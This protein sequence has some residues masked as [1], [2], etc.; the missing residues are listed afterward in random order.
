MKEVW[1]QWLK[2]VQS[3]ISFPRFLSR[4]AFGIENSTLFFDILFGITENDTKEALAKREKEI[5]KKSQ[6]QYNCKAPEFENEWINKQLEMVKQTYSVV[7]K[8]FEDDSDSEQLRKKCLQ[9]GMISTFIERIRIL[10]HEN[11]KTKLIEACSDSDTDQ[12]QIETNA[13][14]QERDKNRK[15]VGYT[16]DVG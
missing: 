9:N 8:I 1:D 15:G 2:E 12:D 16:T 7:Q 13:K 3:F 4:L 11:A 5:S 14:K 10:T 6:Y